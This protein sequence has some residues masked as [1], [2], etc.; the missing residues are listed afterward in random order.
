M[1]KN[2]ALIGLAVEAIRLTE[3]AFKHK[4]ISLKERFFCHSF[5]VITLLLVF[6]IRYT[7]LEYVP[8]YLISYTVLILIL[9]C[10]EQKTKKGVISW[11]LNLLMTIFLVGFSFF[12]IR[13]GEKFLFFWLIIPSIYLVL[14]SGK[15]FSQWKSIKFWLFILLSISV[16]GL[17]IYFDFN[18]MIILLWFF[19]CLIYPYLWANYFL[20]DKKD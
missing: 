17:L 12:F 5:T 16:Y 8:L 1:I 9:M 11:F 7:A 20:S 3:E 14:W 6:L 10:L 13:F 15:L 19:A 2:L 18:I 4:A